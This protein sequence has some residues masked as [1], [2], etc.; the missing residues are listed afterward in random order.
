MLK[1]E[2]LKRNLPDLLTLADGGKVKSVADWRKRR[3]EIKAILSREEYGVIPPPPLEWSVREDRVDGSFCAGKVTRKDLRMICR[4]ESGEFSFPFC[5]VIPKTGQP[6]AA[7]LHINFRPDVPDRYM[8]TEE[9]CDLG[10]AV[11]SFCYQDVTADNGDFQSGIARLIYGGRERENGEPGK[12]A[13][14]AWAA[15]RVMDYLMTVPQIDQSRIAVAGH[16]RLGKTALLT[17]AF[18]E[19]FSAVLSNNSGCCGDAVF[20]DK[21]GERVADICGSCPYWFCKNFQSYVNREHD[22]PFDQH[23]L[24]ALAAPRKLYVSAAVEDSWADPMSQFLSCCAVG[25]IYQLYQK[26][27]LVCPDRCPEVGDVF[28]DGNVGFHLRSGVH[29]FSRYDW[30][31]FLRFIQ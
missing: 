13:M 2:L 5:L 6:C 7:V 22:M 3:E 12:I 16:S 31:M 26:Q 4:L 19:R 25:E 11:A 10:F 30:Q 23:F 21:A 27:G 29:Y 9:I 8:P 20:R 17:A 14:W 15:M 24:L 18:D 28:G 1:Q